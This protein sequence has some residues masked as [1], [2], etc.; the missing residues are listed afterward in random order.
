MTMVYLVA[1]RVQSKARYLPSVSI[2]LLW[3]VKEQ[4]F[5]I[6]IMTPLFFSGPDDLNMCEKFLLVQRGSAEA[7]K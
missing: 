3:R 6:A 5:L 7:L 4:E 1:S 2:R